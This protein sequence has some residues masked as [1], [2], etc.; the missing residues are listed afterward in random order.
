MQKIKYL[1]DLHQLVVVVMAVKER[2][3]SEDH[4]CEHAAQ[5]P[6]VQAVIIVLQVN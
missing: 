3:F 2:L 6:H 4:S 1:R 5:G